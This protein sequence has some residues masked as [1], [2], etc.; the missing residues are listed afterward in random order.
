WIIAPFYLLG[1]MQRSGLRKSAIASL[2]CMITLSGMVLPFV[3]DRPASF[4]DGVFAHWSHTFNAMTL[5][6][7]YFLTRQLST[8]AMKYFQAAAIAVIF[9]SAWKSVPERRYEW[10]TYA[11][12]AFIL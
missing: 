8:S 2:L 3:I 11:L 9:F 12:L 1:I 6:L 4:Y 7:S 5:N 10:M